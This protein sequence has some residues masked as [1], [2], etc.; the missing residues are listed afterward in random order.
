M[1]NQA[2]P[3]KHRGAQQSQVS[4]TNL[5]AA[6]RDH[7][8]RSFL[9][10]YQ[11]LLATPIQTGL[12][13][14]V[15][16]IALALPAVLYVCL[17]NVQ[18]LG[19]GWQ[20]NTQISVY[21]TPKTRLEDAKRLMVQVT[22]FPSVKSVKLIDADTGLAEFQE[23]SGLGD[24]L[25]QLED[26]PLVHVLEV[27]PVASISELSTLKALSVELAKYN[28][29]DDVQIDMNWL[30]RLYSMINLAEHLV[31][32]LALLLALGV[33]LIIGNTIRLAIENRR[34]EIIVSKLVGATNSFVRR[35]FLYTGFLYGLAGG[36]LA[37]L[38]LLLLITWLAGPI[39]QLVDAYNTDYT[40]Q[41]MGV[42]QIISLV[43]A[44]ALLGWVG[45][46]TAV[47]R[48]LRY[49]EPS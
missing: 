16:A 5:A 28:L 21:L 48:H 2:Q 4:M 31:T 41:G 29:V 35:P 46:W 6:W 43:A 44:A 25:R 20:S 1:D 19:Q 36:L 38:I 27:I 24:S 3:K 12:T 47:G 8:K 40:L 30:R 9:A 26:N 14:L 39:G 42:M 15:I 17:A 32:G 33:L 23:Y 10:S 11:R 22:E 18:G 49:I 45:A 13:L 7:H 37:S 34:K